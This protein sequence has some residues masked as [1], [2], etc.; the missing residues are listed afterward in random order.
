MMN[1]E[2][3]EKNVDESRRWLIWG[4]NPAGEACQEASFRT[5]M[6]TREIPE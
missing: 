1:E 4:T 6:R 3:I 2:W 5:E